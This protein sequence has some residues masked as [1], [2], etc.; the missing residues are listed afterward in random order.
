[1]KRN[2]LTL[3][4]GMLMASAAIIAV[5]QRTAQTRLSKSEN[6]AA[7][8][9]SQ[10]RPRTVTQGCESTEAEEQPWKAIRDY[11]HAQ[12]SEAPPASSPSGRMPA[13]GSTTASTNMVAEPQ[14]TEYLIASVPDPQTTHLAL[15]FDRSIESLIWAV[16]DS[17]Y[18]FE[19]YWIPWSA[20]AEPEPSSVA[21]RKCRE[22]E[23][24]KKHGSPGVL[25]FRRRRQQFADPHAKAAASSG[26]EQKTAQATGNFLLLFLVGESPSTGVNLAA[27]NAAIQHVRPTAPQGDKLRMIGP[28]FSGSFEPLVPYL[29]DFLTINKTATIRLI[30]GT[31]T[32]H[33]AITQFKESLG[34]LKTRVPIDFV[35]E[36][37]ERAGKL[38]FNFLKDRRFQPGESALL[39]EDDTAYGSVADAIVRGSVDLQRTKASD[40]SHKWLSLRYPR[41]IARLRNAVQDVAPNTSSKPPDSLVQGADP[42]LR[43]ASDENGAL[44]KDNVPSFSKVQSP[45][46]Q[47]AVLI[48]I[49]SALRREHVRYTGIIATDI[50]DSLFLSRFL[51]LSFPD[52]RVFTLESDL[53]FPREGENTPFTG[54]L[55]ITTYPLL[56]RN[57]HWTVAQLR[58]GIPRRVPFVSRYAEGTYNACRYMLQGDITYSASQNGE[59]L[60]E[61]GRPIKTSAGSTSPKH[62]PPLWLTVLGRQGYWPVALLDEKE[63]DQ[64]AKES[65]LLALNNDQ[66]TETNEN[67]HPESPSGGWYLWTGAILLFSILHCIYVLHLVSKS[68]EYTASPALK[69]SLDALGLLFRSYP[70]IPITDYEIP[71]L[72]AF[73][74]VL[75]CGSYFLTIMIARFEPPPP[76]TVSQPFY[77]LA[78]AAVLLLFAVAAVLLCVFFVDR[79]PPF[80]SYLWLVI[81]S[82][83]LAFSF[84]AAVTCLVHDDSFQEGYFFAYRSLNLTSGVSPTVPLLLLAIPYLFWGWMQLH[85]EKLSRIRRDAQPPSAPTQS[86]PER[87]QDQ[88]ERSLEGI[89][90]WRVL[91]PAIVLTL[92]W[93]IALEP[94]STVRSFEWY[95]YDWLYWSA[96]GLLFYMTA[97]SFVHLRVCWNDF[98]DYLQMLERSPIRQAFSRLGKQITWV[99]LLAKLPESQFLITTL[100]GEALAAIHEFTFTDPA[101]RVLWKATKQ[102]ITPVADHALATLRKCEQDIAESGRPNPEDYAALQCDFENIRRIVSSHLQESEWSKGDS[103]S[104]RY[105]LASGEKQTLSER[106]RLRIIEEEFIALRHVFFMRYVFRHLRNLLLFVVVGF[107][108]SVLSLESYPFQGQRWI[109]FIFIVSLVVTGTGVGIIF[110]QMDRDAILSRLTDTKQNQLSKVFVFRMLQYGTLPLLTVISTQFPWFHRAVSSIVQPAIEALH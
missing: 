24:A 67:I 50:L 69:N 26:N 23:L 29:R 59:L 99:P 51:R 42:A 44:Q 30:S 109:N 41:E 31:V 60:L 8:S 83:L 57:Q 53:L 64:D 68:R 12:V 16:G 70:R 4:G 104:L 35:I 90:S 81:P 105:E 79:K 75:L 21:D 86:G 39:S 96:L 78:I 14:N 38:F 17:G 5:G 88:I 43:D 40:V 6:P 1:M 22:G 56:S 27:L 20:R 19:Q 93:L 84:C 102:Q 76:E 87:Y 33:E 9:T 95:L 28:T 73:T 101:D 100:S 91:R 49:S 92:I 48:S 106:S 94:W 37:D 63:K 11:F 54:I 108:F 55:C 45:S 34:S 36:N 3:T 15:F 107:I 62:R 47:Q 110:A 72:L 74:L 85:R 66:A 13:S 58:G 7:S 10:T 82:V 25:I 80:K 61:Y 103:E 77:W 46:S 97:V 2:G 18:T 52:T 65:T 32:S 98:R 89:L 71:F